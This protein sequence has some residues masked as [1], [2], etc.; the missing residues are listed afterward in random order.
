MLR[1]VIGTIGMLMEDNKP[2]G[3]RLIGI[4]TTGKLKLVDMP[5]EGVLDKFYGHPKKVVLEILRSMGINL[6]R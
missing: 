1:R 5:L 3:I 6:R 2:V 4:T